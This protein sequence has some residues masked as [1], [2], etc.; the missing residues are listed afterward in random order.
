[1][2]ETDH[3]TLWDVLLLCQQLTGVGQ[4]LGVPPQLMQIFP[5]QITALQKRSCHLLA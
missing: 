1:M 5:G 3:R 2:L 4:G